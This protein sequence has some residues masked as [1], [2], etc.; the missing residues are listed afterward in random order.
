MLP[1]RDF[2]IQPI[3]LEDVARMPLPGLNIPTKVEFSPDDELISYLQ[4]SEGG[5][6]QQLFAYHIDSGESS[7]LVSPLAGSASEENLSL[8]ESLR[9]ERLRRVELGVTDYA[10]S[11]KGNHLLV[12]LDGD[13]FISETAFQ[14]L[15]K[16]VT[17]GGTPIQDACF[18]PDGKWVTFVQDAEIYII[19]SAGG[20]VKQVT[21]GARENGLTHGLAEYIAQEEMGRQ[22][23]YWWSA[24]SQWLAYTQVD[25][26]NI[27]SYRILHQG[28]DET[29]E[30]AQEDH[31]YP[32]AGKKNASVR[33]GVMPGQGG[34]TQWI[35][36]PE[37]DCYLARVHWFPDGRL[38]Y[39]IENREQTQLDFY[40]FNPVDNSIVKLLTESSHIWINLHD[41]FKPLHKP[42]DGE[43]GCFLWASERSGYRHLY[44][45]NRQGQLLR[46]LTQGEWMVDSLVGLDEDQ[47][48]VYFTGTKDSPL[49]S[50]L[51]VVSLQGGQPR[52]I[53][54]EAGTHQVVMDHD[55]RYFVD[56]F[57]SIN[58]PPHQ[59]L[60]SLENGSKQAVLFEP[61]DPRLKSLDLLAPELVDITNRHGT[62][63]YGALY[64][65]EEKFGPGP[66]PTVV[67]VYGGPHVQMVVNSW[68]LTVRM[69]IQ[70]L[71][72]LGFLVFTL[73]NRGSARRGLV[74]EGEIK[75]NMGDLEVDDQV[76]GVQWLI[77]QGLT[78][79]DRVGING[80]S[81]GGYMSAMCLLKAP[82]IFKAAVAGA[83][84]SDWDGYDTHYTERYMGTPTSN[85]QGYK[86]AS[87][88]S[89]VANLGGSL[90]IVHG[91]ID[92]NVHFRHSARLINALIRERKQYDLL[93]F[94]DE[95]H[96]P[97][98]IADRVYME[99]R[100]RDFFLE[101]LNPEQLS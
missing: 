9:R 91:L 10:W 81:Y 12:P 78:D 45:Y 54:Q 37:Q 8:E 95:R 39:E 7:L 3:P 50:H 29:G 72:S 24:D 92:E 25:E 66:Y 89:H 65:P 30:R 4:S 67:F 62:K 27:P 1:E 59:F 23:G 13:L 77:E 43:E 17:G 44:L 58:S 63:L 56:T 48:L 99:E 75:N 34:Q 35:S 32:F 96:L 79:A 69:R 85:P 42:L 51:Y 53:T 36:F 20:E 64:K 11:Q 83:P 49:E 86:N 15:R 5:L 93:L 88:L 55:G 18:S 97:R 101:K 98:K 47:Q 87:L 19:S 61:V 71:R 100:I 31:H 84:V 28:K 57:H 82:E 2:S 40:V 80:W 14:S 33:L 22:K 52:K 90:M 41:L 16:L 26:T 74:F 38:G 6:V 70:Y 76:D 21:S 68:L 60:C 73:D 94:P 46:Q